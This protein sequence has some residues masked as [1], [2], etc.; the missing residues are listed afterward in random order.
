MTNSTKIFLLLGAALA[1]WYIPT[2]IAL[3]KLN[4]SLF[5]FL[6]SKITE[7]NIDAILG[8]KIK[9]PSGTR[10]D[11]AW[12]K[13]DIL[14]NGLKI[15]EFAQNN[16]FVI[17]E[18]AEQNFNV[19]ITIDAVQVGQKV[20][21]ELIAANLQNFVIQVKGSLGA[22]GKMLPFDTYFTIKDITA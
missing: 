5:S 8:V 1:Y 17:M 18:N 16:P 4:I 12:I 20:W 2:I 19:N 10:I 13:G 22:N 3:K 6:P 7:T 15:S 21:D 14:F 11:L 9:N